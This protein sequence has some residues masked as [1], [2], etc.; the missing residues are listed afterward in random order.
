[1]LH[2]FPRGVQRV[3][4]RKR[5]Y[6]AMRRAIFKEANAELVAK[7]SLANDKERF[8]IWNFRI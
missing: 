1:M 8:L 7:F 3:Q 4:E 5:Q 2:M 6:S